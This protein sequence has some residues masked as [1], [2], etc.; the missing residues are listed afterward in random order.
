MRFK[1]TPNPS[2]LCMCGCGQ[3]TRIADVT[4]TALCK[5]K[6]EP[7]RYIHGH[8]VRSA[9]H[10]YVINSDTGCWEWQWYVM[11]DGYALAT[12]PHKNTSGGHTDYAHRV[13]YRM[14]KGAIPDEYHIDHLC[15]NRRCVNPDHLEAVTPSVN[16]RRS[17]VAK[18]TERDIRAIRRLIGSGID[19]SVIADQFGV[20]KKH[21]Q[22][23][24]RG[25]VWRGIH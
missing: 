2:G 21:I 9:P 1:C 17:S 23:I 6:G 13:Y 5:V 19:A 8:R 10:P 16:I 15:K 7:M 20:G 11:D 24:G 14:Y 22:S 3:R 25:S 4:N 12:D 18:L